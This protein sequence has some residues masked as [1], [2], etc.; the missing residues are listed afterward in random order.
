MIM[1]FAINYLPMM[2]STFNAGFIEKKCD[3]ISVNYS[4]KG[5][6]VEFIVDALRVM[7]AWISQF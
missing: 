4:S 2:C 3:A 6:I 5:G 1:S 7:S